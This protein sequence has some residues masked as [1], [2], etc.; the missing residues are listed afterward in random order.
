M[1]DLPKQFRRSYLG[2]AK[3]GV[4]EINRQAEGNASKRKALKEEENEK[5]RLQ[6]KGR[7]RKEGAS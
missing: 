1:N 6:G 3:V 2:K 5:R 7:V 4:A